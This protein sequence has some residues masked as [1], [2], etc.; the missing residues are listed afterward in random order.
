MK[1]SAKIIGELAKSA[2]QDA[3]K[4]DELMQLV[5]RGRSLQAANPRSSLWRRIAMEALSAAL[6]GDLDAVKAFVKAG[7]APDENLP[8]FHWD[9]TLLHHAIH[10]KETDVLRFLVNLGPNLDVL[11]G[12]GRTP[13]HTTFESIP[14]HRAHAEILARAGADLSAKG[15]ERSPLFSPADQLAYVESLRRFKS[16]M[17]KSPAS[18][19]MPQAVKLK[20]TLT[21][22]ALI[23]QDI[24]YYAGSIMIEGIEF[25]VDAVQTGDLSA[26]SAVNPKYQD[27]IGVERFDR[28]TR[29]GW[30]RV[31]INDLPHLL[32]IYP[33]AR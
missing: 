26:L 9:S 27:R 33:R 29:T 1:H 24:G 3:S 15:I 19:A 7:I 23:R 28:T 6:S 11:N 2:K 31:Y 18:V 5:A 21:D 10:P 8:S 22:F 30:D 20:L 16:G 4:L 32:L 25:Q 12:R 14:A 17:A 13:L